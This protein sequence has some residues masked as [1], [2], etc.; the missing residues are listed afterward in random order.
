MGKHE[1]FGGIVKKIISIRKQNRTF[2]Y[3][4]KGKNILKNF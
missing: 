1:T 3:G 4:L 2:A